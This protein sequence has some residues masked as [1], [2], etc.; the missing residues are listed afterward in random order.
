MNKEIQILFE[1]EKVPSC[2][3][4]KQDRNKQ[5]SD[6]DCLTCLGY[7]RSDDNIFFILPKTMKDIASDDDKRKDIKNSDLPIWLYGAID[8]YR[9]RVE[10]RIISE[11]E[12]QVVVSSK[13]SIEET[14]LL[15]HII[16]LRNFY[17]R[18]RNLILTVYKESRRGYNRINWPKTVRKSIPIIWN[19]SGR[20]QVAYVEVFNEHRHI[21]DQEKLMVL[22]FSTM[23]YIQLKYGVDMPKNE[24][25]TLLTEIEFDNMMECDTVCGKLKAIQQQYFSDHMRELWKILYA[26]HSKHSNETSHHVEEY[27]L[28]THFD[29]VFEDMVDNLLSDPKLE[30]L[31]HHTDNRHIDHI[32]LGTIKLHK[33]VDDLGVY[34]I[35]DSKYYDVNKDIDKQSVA[36]QYDYAR[37][38]IQMVMDRKNKEHPIE[39][40]DE[41]LAGAFYDDFTH[42]YAIT[43]NF[44][45]R[46]RKEDV[47]SKNLDFAIMKVKKEGRETD[48][49]EFIYQHKDCLFDR[50]T[51][52]LLTYEI[53]LSN[54]LEIYAQ[55]DIIAKEDAKSRIKKVVENDLM[56]HIKEKYEREVDNFIESMTFDIKKIGK[57]FKIGNKILRVK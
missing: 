34:Y 13:D 49:I 48:K 10:T 46:P 7:Y 4:F 32:F 29:R 28:S 18:N 3:L 12:G 16:A 57:E 20:N 36:K 56:K 21:H 54:L 38:I 45:I 40:I 33:D 35:A 1:G 2:P 6:K 30:P 22:Y 39:A 37:N 17:R 53:N 31:K 25:Y 9:R 27:L 42:G 51:L 52:F 47:L 43:P 24:Y 50:S 41:K 23:R 44:F 14:N 26:F 11:P 55:D 15:D 8:T 19:N 5:F